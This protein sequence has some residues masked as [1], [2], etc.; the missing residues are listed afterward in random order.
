MSDLTIKKKMEAAPQY[1]PLLNGAAVG[2]AVKDGI[3]TLTGH[4]TTYTQKMVAA[5]AAEGGRG[6]F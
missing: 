3:V 5:R 6:H 4:I 2:V 1:K